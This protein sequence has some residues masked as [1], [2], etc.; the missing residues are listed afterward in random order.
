[1]IAVCPQPHGRVKPSML[2]VGSRVL[3]AADSSNSARACSSDELGKLRK[4]TVTHY[5][6][7][8]LVILRTS[9]STA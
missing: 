5:N 6:S 7:T 1:V 3:T 9:S 8:T 4:R 2:C